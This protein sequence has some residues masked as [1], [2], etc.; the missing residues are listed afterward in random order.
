M[1]KTFFL[2]II[3]STCMN[4]VVVIAAAAAAA[5]VVVIVV[6]VVKHIQVICF[7]Q[8]LSVFRLRDGNED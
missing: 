1:C 6:V 3:F 5:A 7:E 8:K 2:G 4:N